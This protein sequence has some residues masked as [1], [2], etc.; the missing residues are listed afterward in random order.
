MKYVYIIFISPYLIYAALAGP[1]IKLTAFIYFKLS[2]IY[3]FI[4]HCHCSFE[5]YLYISYKVL[6]D[7]LFLGCKLH[8]FCSINLLFFYLMI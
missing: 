8:L 7:E 3:S 1:D 2:E 4:L 5:I 6:K